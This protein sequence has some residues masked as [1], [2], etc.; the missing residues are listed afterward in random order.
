[1][2]RAGRV[3]DRLTSAID[4]DRGALRDRLMTARTE[5]RDAAARIADVE[6]RLVTQEHE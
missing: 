4:G 5:M 3:V 2:H 1:V 6:R